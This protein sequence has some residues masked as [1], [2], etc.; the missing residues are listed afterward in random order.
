MRKSDHVLE[1]VSPNAFFDGDLF[2][3][4]KIWRT[5]HFKYPRCTNK[6]LKLFSITK[7]ASICTSSKWLT[8]LLKFLTFKSGRGNSSGA[9]STAI[10][11]HRAQQIFQGDTLRHL[12][13]I[14]SP[15]GNWRPLRVPSCRTISSLAN[16]PETL[17]AK[18]HW[19]S[20]C[21]GLPWQHFGET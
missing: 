20:N 7:L 18:D 6:G 14:S 9:A 10:Q 15:G 2:V 1:F 17:L 21:Q 4:P 11:S 5:V 13:L 12:I 19:R 16:F 3:L 8:F